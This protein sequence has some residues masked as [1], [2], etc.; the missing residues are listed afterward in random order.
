MTNFCHHIGIFTNNPRELARFYTEKLG[1]KI[2]ETK[3]VPEDLVKK[4]F[5]IPSSCRL[6]KLKLGQVI[7]EILS[8]D[9]LNLKKRLNDVS[10][11]N[12]WGLAVQNKED[13][14]RMLKKQGVKILKYKKNGHTIFFAKDPEGNLVEIYEARRTVP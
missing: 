5:G 7:I 8:P 9:N 11:Y 12:H 14:C 13:F 4:I 3:E 10:G 6:T 1:F 2:G